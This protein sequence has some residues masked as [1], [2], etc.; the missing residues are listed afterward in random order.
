MK[1][2]EYDDQLKTIFIVMR[3][4]EPKLLIAMNRIEPVVGVERDV[5]FGE[6]TAAVEPA[7]GAS[8]NPAFR[9]NDKALDRAGS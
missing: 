6:P 4:E 2:I 9:Q 8:N 1:T 5:I 7:D 3:I